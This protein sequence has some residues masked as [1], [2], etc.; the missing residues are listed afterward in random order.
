[1]ARYTIRWVTYA[2]Q[3]RDTLPAEGRREL[4]ALLN[5]LADDPYRHGTYDKRTELRRA[6]FGYGLLTYSVEERWITITVL[7]VTWI[8]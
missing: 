7:R 4:N 2:E 5:R 1:M 6:V 8:G 3:Q